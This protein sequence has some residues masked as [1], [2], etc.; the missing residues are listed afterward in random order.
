VWAGL[1]CF[2]LFDS[3]EA[4]QAAVPDGFRERLTDLPAFKHV[5]THKDL[6]LHPVQ[7]ELPHE[8]EPTASGAWFEPLQWQC[9]GLPAPVNK[10][11]R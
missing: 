1:Y 10:L 11:L 6:H 3:H 4:L 2:A 9:L 7:V 8:L 5:L